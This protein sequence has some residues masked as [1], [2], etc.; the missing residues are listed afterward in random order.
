MTEIG[1][2]F[3]KKKNI[4]ESLSR[5]FDCA[6]YGL[7]SIIIAYIVVITPHISS[8]IV[9]IF[10]FFIFTPGELVQGRSI[11]PFSWHAFGQ[12]FIAGRQR[13]AGE[14]RE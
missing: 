2:Q 5:L 6:V 4:N 9:F 10:F 13:S 7:A 8:L 12:H 11:L 3:K 14:T 1:R